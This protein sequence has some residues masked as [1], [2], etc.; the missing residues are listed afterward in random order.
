MSSAT[1]SIAVLVETTPAL[2]FNDPAKADELF[3][4]IEQEITTAPVD[5]ASDKGRKAVAS[6][7]Y[8]IS[9]TKTA[10]DDAGAELIQEAN[11]KVQSVNAERRK[12]RNRLD[13]LRDKARK[14]LDDWEAE[15]AKRKTQCQAIVDGLKQA[16][17]VTIEDTTETLRARIKQ[18]Q[19]TELHLDYLGDFFDV[20]SDARDT[21]LAILNSA[22]QRQIHLDEERI[23]LARLR[24]E[25]ERRNAAEAAERKAREDA[26]RKAAYVD[27]QIKHIVNCGLGLID[28]RPYPIIILRRELQEKVVIDE[29]FGDRREE[30]EAAKLAALKSLDDVEERQRV[31]Q[32]AAEEARAAEAEAD[33]QRREREAAQRV[34][35]E[36]EAQRLREEEEA[37]ARAADQR[38]RTTIMLDA[39]EAVMRAAG[40][41]KDKAWKIITA[42]A[43]GS[44]PHTTIKF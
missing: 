39:E 23:E 34:L 14:P 28:G 6:L 32:V 41:G 36:A 42:I 4:H 44:I 31:E 7:A 29:S 22:L 38:H 24:E 18:V 40:I 37:D 2:V 25:A 30:A 26:E 5:L 21:S 10:I 9:R 8:K 11:K 12:L 3:A 1:T 17:K 19:N 35:D 43:A 33:A 15:Q 16:G 13:A 27:A 20:A